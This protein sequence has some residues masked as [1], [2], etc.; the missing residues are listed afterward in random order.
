MITHKTSLDQDVYV[1]LYLT[2]SQLW[3]KAG[4]PNHCLLYCATT[5]GRDCV[6]LTLCLHSQTLSII[7]KPQYDVLSLANHSLGPQLLWLFRCLHHDI[8]SRGWCPHVNC[9]C[10][11]EPYG[12]NQLFSVSFLSFKHV[13]SVPCDVGDVMLWFILKSCTPGVCELA[14]QQHYNYWSHIKANNSH[15]SSTSSLHSTKMGAD[16]RHPWYFFCVCFLC[17]SICTHH[18][19]QD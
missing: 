17:S 16:I 4:A 6:G 11:W 5:K 7:T 13:D 2:A 19:A 10:H 14:R 9:L 3:S 8:Y 15:N 18:A 12:W 1:N